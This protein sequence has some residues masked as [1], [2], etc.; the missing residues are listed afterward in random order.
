MVNEL[1]GLEQQIRTLNETYEHK[2]EHY[3]KWIRGKHEENL[4]IEKTI[5]AL[6]GTLGEQVAREPV[7]EPIVITSDDLVCNDSDDVGVGEP[8]T[9]TASNESHEPV[10]VCLRKSDKQ[11]ELNKKLEAIPRFIKK[12]D[13]EIKNGTRAVPQREQITLELEQMLTEIIGNPDDASVF[14]SSTKYKKYRDYITD[15]I[16]RAWGY[17]ICPT[18]EWKKAKVE[19]DR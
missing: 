19:S 8:V 13:D 12:L 17:K 11:K 3:D 18:K 1:K 14:S 9:I 6:Q 15:K 2:K 5:E 10:G 16:P 7:S 4:E